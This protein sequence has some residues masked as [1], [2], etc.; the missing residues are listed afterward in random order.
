MLRWRILTLFAAT[1]LLAL[2]LLA[3]GSAQLSGEDEIASGIDLSDY[4]LT[5]E[6]EFDALDVSGRGCDTRW[7]AHTPWNGDFGAAIFTDPSA[8]FPFTVEDGVL[9]IEASKDT[10]GKWYSGLLSSW[11]TCDEGFAQAYGYFEIRA[12]LPAGSGFWPAFWLIGVDRERYTAEIDVF[13]YHSIR[14]SRFSSTLHVHPRA[15]DIERYNEFFLTEVEPGSLA[16]DFHLWGVSLEE[17]EL[18]LYFDR[19]EIG[20]APMR[21]EYRQ[22]MFVLLN[23]AMD[24]GE[25]TSETPDTDYMYV[26]YVKVYAKR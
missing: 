3:R 16:E 15:D 22:P 25:I 8:R 7:I 17:D 14:P 11:N 26:D 12:R 4:E 6:E 21:E 9:R 20:R 24:K 13:E 1:S 2:S 5:F 23:L 19:R 10:D 18:V